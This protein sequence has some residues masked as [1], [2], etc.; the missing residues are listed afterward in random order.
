[1]LRSWFMGLSEGTYSLSAAAGEA[2]WGLDWVSAGCGVVLD[3]AAGSASVVDGSGLVSAGARSA[4]AG[5]E[6]L[7]VSADG[8]SS[9]GTGTSSCRGR[10]GWDGGWKVLARLRCASR[11][12]ALPTAVAPHDIENPCLARTRYNLACAATYLAA[13]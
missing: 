1:M 6:V 7:F 3:C 2:C 12:V 5:R 9:C 8:V 11:S 4:G 13:G 10:Q